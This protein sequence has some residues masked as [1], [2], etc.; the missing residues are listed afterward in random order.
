[1]KKLFSI[2][3]CAKW[4]RVDFRPSGAAA[5][6]LRV[7]EVKLMFDQLNPEAVV[8]IQEDDRPKGQNHMLETLT[9]NLPN[10]EHVSK[11]DSS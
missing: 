9:H 6:N 2:V 10:Q 7:R 11:H 8:T 1:M 3:Y 4:C 5:L